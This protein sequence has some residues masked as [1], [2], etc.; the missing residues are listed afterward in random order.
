MTSILGAIEDEIAAGDIE[1][2]IR[3]LKNLKRHVDGCGDVP[4]MN[5]WITD[6]PSQI[7]VQELIDML[8]GNLE[9]PVGA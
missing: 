4:D 5:D 9:A 2:A 6:C 1:E 8:I 7:R 3:K